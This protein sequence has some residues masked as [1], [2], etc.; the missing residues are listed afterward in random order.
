M[1]YPNPP[2]SPSNFQTQT[3]IDTGTKATRMAK[4]GTIDTLLSIEKPAP[5][6]HERCLRAQPFR[7]PLRRKCPQKARRAVLGH[8]QPTLVLLQ[9][10][11][12]GEGA[13]GSH[14]MGG[15]PDNVAGCVDW[16]T[17][18]IVEKHETLGC[19]RGQWREKSWK[20]HHEVSRTEDVPVFSAKGASLFALQNPVYDSTET[21]VMIWE[22]S[23]LERLEY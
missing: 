4:A 19:W 8:W 3:G 11:Q 2:V 10:L 17:K 22:N 20:N 12:S 1:V 23:C 9:A 7:P 21:C 18:A 15:A 14:P 6:F 5:G 16:E 13:G